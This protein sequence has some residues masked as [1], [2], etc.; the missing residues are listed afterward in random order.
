M[1]ETVFEGVKPKKSKML[2][3][4][5]MRRE[6]VE[7]MAKGED[8]SAV[9]ESLGFSSQWAIK[10]LAGAY[11]EDNLTGDA[12]RQFLAAGK[13][14]VEEVV[15]RV[16]ASI[17]RTAGETGDELVDFKNLLNRHYKLQRRMHMLETWAKTQG[18]TNTPEEGEAA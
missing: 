11:K 6:A 12:V 17:K 18:F 7:R 15:S 5:A 4:P 1:N 3:T 16:E 8:Y 9:S 2:A 13:L 10:I 14:A